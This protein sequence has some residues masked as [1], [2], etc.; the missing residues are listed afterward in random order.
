MVCLDLLMLFD[1]LLQTG[2]A[3]LDLLSDFLFEGKFVVFQVCDW[4]NVV[5]FMHNHLGVLCHQAM[6]LKQGAIKHC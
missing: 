5:I 4:S 6:C 1:H 3:F 2:F